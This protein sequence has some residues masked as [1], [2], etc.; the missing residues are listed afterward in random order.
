MPLPNARSRR[1]LL[2]AAIVAAACGAYFTIASDRLPGG[3]AWPLVDLSGIVVAAA[4]IVA[5]RRARERALAL[6]RTPSR[7]LDPSQIPQAPAKVYVG[8]GFAWTVECAEHLQE[9]AA[10]PDLTANPSEDDGRAFIHGVGAEMERALFV[11]AELLAQHTV[12][13]GAPGSGKTRALEILI[14]QAIERGDAVVVIDPKGDERLLDQVRQAARQ[15]GRER[16]FRLFALPY[17]D[18]SATYNPLSTYSQPGEIADRLAL[19]LPQGGDATSFRNYARDVID[20]VA[21]ALH[22]AGIAVTITALERYAVS[23]DR[24]APELL[25][26][27]ILQVAPELLLTDAI[28]PDTAVAVYRR[29]V[30]SGELRRDRDVERVIELCNRPREHYL[31]MINPLLPLFGTL[32]SGANSYLLSPEDNR[33]PGGP[34]PDLT[35]ASIDRER[36]VGYFFLGS[37][38]GYDT[39]TGVARMTL[40]DLQSYIGQKYHYEA[41]ANYGRVSLFVDEAA[42]VLR[43]ASAN[44]LN[45]GRGAEL[46]VTLSMQTINDLFIALEREPVAMQ[47]LSNINTFVQLRAQNP[48]DAEY[49]SERA[50]ERE[51]KVVMQGTM[52]EPTLLSSGDRSVDDFRARFSTSERRQ[53]Q[54]IV[55]P[56]AVLELPRWHY[57]AVWAGRV[58]KGVFPLLR[59]QP[60]EFPALLKGFANTAETANS[61]ALEGGVA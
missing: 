20:I 58:Y 47:V 13:A 57:F 34:R 31:K 2:T 9:L 46:A 27:L 45:K 21:T 49:F 41:V 15:A 40:A 12:I 25:K 17:P 50:G 6:A 48:R 43:P 4:A 3:R 52:Y 11:P 53:S 14:R 39:A 59:Y 35:W 10:R 51:L 7:L 54:A 19:L 8:D 32:A 30:A 44:L 37:L 29:A 28:D 26:R 61:R 56:W 5:W 38:I 24:E 60:S 1:L 42:D 22:R 18:A 33:H 23:I 16:D 55:P 36:L